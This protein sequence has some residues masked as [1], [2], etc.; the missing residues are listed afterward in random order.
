YGDGRASGPTPNARDVLCLGAAKF[1]LGR[2]DVGP[3]V[4]LFKGACVAADGALHCEGASAPNRHVTLRAEMDVIVL[5]AVTPH[6]LDPRP[7]YEG[8]EVQVTARRGATTAADDAARATSPERQRAFENTDEWLL[9][10][11]R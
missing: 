4:N 6:P 7:S 3:S 2:V 1:G 5:L 8:N 11:D 9:G 10:F